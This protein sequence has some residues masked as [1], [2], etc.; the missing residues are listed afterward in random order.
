MLIVEIALGIVLGWLIIKHFDAVIDSIFNLINGFF[1]IILFPFKLAFKIFK[2]IAFFAKEV[3]FGL[4][5]TTTKILKWVIPIAI[6][7]GIAYGLF[8]LLFDFVPQPYSRYI[9]FLIFGG[10]LLYGFSVMMKESL[11]NYKNKTSKH[12]LYGAFVS[13]TVILILLL[14]AVNGVF[15][16]FH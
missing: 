3:L 13:I 11:E 12:W 15:A 10:A 9:F 6:V 14:V 5:Y 7:V 8:Y 2:G 4:T 1:R 16:I